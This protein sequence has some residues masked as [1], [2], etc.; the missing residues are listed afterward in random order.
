MSEL[1][2]GKYLKRGSVWGGIQALAPYPFLD[3][4]TPDQLNRQLDLLYGERVL[5][6]KFS[7]LE[8]PVAADLIFVQFN[9]KWLNLIK[10]NSEVFNL[11]ASVSNKKTE[12]TNTTENS[13][14]VSDTVNKVSAFNTD[15][16]IVD[17]GSDNSET[18][19][20]D[21]TA[22]KVTTDDK[23]SLDS[24]YNNLTLADKISIIKVV[25]K[26]IAQFLS[27]SIY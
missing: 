5:F 22:S 7:E 2:L 15:D 24:A 19:D 4:Y 10:V 20:K 8:I 13:T 21:T 14:K 17:G 16:L 18:G 1:T 25:N 27:L 6:T 12:T 9:E 11:A 23:I 26:D 3:T